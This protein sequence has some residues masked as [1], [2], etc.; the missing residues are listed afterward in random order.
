MRAQS[1]TSCLLAACAAMSIASATGEARPQTTLTCGRHDKLV[2][3]LRMKFKESRRITG[4]VNERAFMEIF[5]SPLGTWTVVITDSNGTACITAA[6][7]DW[8]DVPI[9]VAGIDS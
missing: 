9:A 6:G 2:D 3:V 8:Q 1:I 7:D 4:L 5:M